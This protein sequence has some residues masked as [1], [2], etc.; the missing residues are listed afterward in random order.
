M[1]CAQTLAPRIPR[2]YSEFL[3]S[4]PHGFSTNPAVCWAKPTNKT[5]RS[6]CLWRRRWHF[7]SSTITCSLTRSAGNRRI[8]NRPLVLHT[9]SYTCLVS[10]FRTS[11]CSGSSKGRFSYSPIPELLFSDCL[12]LWKSAAASFQEQSGSERRMKTTKQRRHIG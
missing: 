8:C 5:A 4:T 1:F 3:T 9:R 7:A 12:G 10:L 6:Y 2:D 11:G